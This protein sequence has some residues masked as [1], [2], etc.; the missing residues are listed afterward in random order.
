MPP[1]AR[2]VLEQQRH[3]R[4]VR[5]IVED[6]DAAIELLGET[7]TSREAASRMTS[8]AGRWSRTLKAIWSVAHQ[9]LS[10]A[11]R[12]AAAAAKYTWS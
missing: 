9:P 7:P 3:V 2:R 8:A 12:A 10:M 11:A 6:A 4:G 1:R 5:K